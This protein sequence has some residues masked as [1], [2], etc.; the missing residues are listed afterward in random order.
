MRK[1]TLFLLLISSFA[2]AQSGRRL[3][4]LFLGDD[5]HHK[6]ID[7]LP[8]LMAALGPQGINFTYTDKLSDLNSENL[9]QYDALMLYANIDVI[10]KAA[11]KALLNFVAS[12]KGFLPIHCAS[13]CFRNSPDFVKLV[14]GQFWRHTMDSIQTQ[15]VQPNHPIMKGL[16]SFNVF[17]ETYLHTRLQS[18]NNI[19]AIREIK[20]DQRNDKPNEKTEPYTWTRTHGKGKVFYTAYGHDDRTWSDE[21]F[22]Q[23]LF[24][25]IVWSVND[26]A[27]AAFQARNVKPFEYRAAQLPNY[28]RRQGEQLQ[29]LPLSPEESMKHI[30]LP[31]EFDL[32]LFAAEPDVM[33]PIAMTWDEKGRLYVLIT[34]D[35]PNERKPEGGGDYI[36]MCEDTDKDGKADKFTR[37]AD[38]MSIPTGMVFANG[39]LVVTQ[40]PDILFFEDTDGDNKADVKKT[41]YSGFGTYD[42]H[43][44]PS[45]LKYGFDNWIW[46]SVGYSGYQGVDGNGDTLRFGNALFRFKADGSDLQWMTS[47]SNNTWGM[48]FN[49]T[50]DIFASTA[51]NSHGW[52]LAIPNQFFNAANRTNNGSRGTDTHKNMTP[53]TPKVRQ[54]DVFGGFTAAS[55]HDFYTARSF[56]K[57]YWNQI[58]FVSEPTGHVLHRN[59]IVKNGTDFSDKQAFNLMAGADEWFSPVFAQ[60]GPD[61]AVWVADWYSF[62]IQHNPKPDGFEMGSGNAYETDLRDFTHGRIY[63]VGYKDAAD[64][65]P[66]VL[67][68]NNPDDLLKALE[69]DNMFWRMQAQR[70]I[71]QR[72][73][74]DA[75]P[76][77]IKLLKNQES[78]EIGINAPAIHALWTLQGLGEASHEIIETGLRHSNA[79]VRKNALKVMQE[80]GFES[81][82]MAARNID[83]V[84]KYNLLYDQEPLVVMNALLVLSQ[85]DLNDEAEVVFLQKLQNSKDVSD[86]WLPDAYSVVLTANNGKL[87]KQLLSKQESARTTNHSSMDHSGHT[88]TSSSDQNLKKSKGIDLIISDVKMSPENPVV[89]ERVAYT[90]EVTNIGSE[91]LPAGVF[92]PFDLRFE[93][94]GQVETLTSRNFKDGIKSGETVSIDQTMNGPWRGNIRFS[95]DIAGDYSLN[96][97]LN[98]VNEVNESNYRNNSYRKTFSFSQPS[99]TEAFALERAVRSYASAVS[100]DELTPIIKEA[101]RLGVQGKN[102]IYRAIADGW[103]FRRKDIEMSPANM[104]YLKS[105]GSTANENLQNVLLAWKVIEPQKTDENVKVVTIK[106]VRE[107]MKYDL[108]EF[109]VK[110]GE[111]VELVFENPDAMQHNLLIIQPNSTEKVGEAADIMAQDARGAERNY[112]P[113]MSEILFSTPLVNPDETFRLRFKAPDVKGDYP[114][115]CTF[116]GHWR[117]MQGVMKVK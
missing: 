48:A 102:A 104:T 68:M 41:L 27:K 34:K 108:T 45:N 2:M 35:Y 60:V 31:V 4:V 61:G 96:I 8:T 23:L 88:M 38:G 116:P 15:T 106:A 117:L 91:D 3:E 78:D 18:D 111:M 80:Q 92:V 32:Q 103:N 11:E 50:N 46:G 24:N 59:H 64:Y 74:K 14:G 30:Q 113:S 26:E 65:E 81:D 47:T 21:G 84:L 98:N 10:D 76:A 1:I 94:M 107:A 112:T 99:N 17:D 86:R 28:E 12:G 75:V 7:R 101:Q 110:A 105:L 63:R 42:T 69:N 73:Q 33:H 51:N 77:L 71:I 58:A 82:A 53:I 100:I 66:V 40:A 43:A 49:E 29:Q 9:N 44:G 97:D 114:Y 55:G 39:G 67:S 70:L 54:V 62:I 13:Y 115:I 87:M 93:G 95:S 79:D 52:Y 109:T 36:L 37:F 85:G 72:G 56:P 19:L 83:L 5:G 22:Q 89:R 16:K 25:A 57:E 6:P 90:V 20:A